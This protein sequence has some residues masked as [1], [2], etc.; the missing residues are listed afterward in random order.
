MQKILSGKYT[1]LQNG[2]L[3]PKLGTLLVMVVELT[4]QARDKAGLE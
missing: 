2:D 3:G 4:Y 1:P